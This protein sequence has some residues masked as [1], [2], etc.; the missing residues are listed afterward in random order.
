MRNSL[1]VFVLPCE[2]LGLWQEERNVI[3]QEIQERSF[4]LN[5]ER[6]EIDRENRFNAP[7][8]RDYSE[9]QRRV[10]EMQ[11]RVEQIIERENRITLNGRR[12][13]LQCIK[14]NVNYYEN[15]PPLRKLS[16]SQNVGSANSRL[17]TLER[18]SSFECSNTS[19]KTL[20]LS[21]QPQS[22]KTRFSRYMNELEPKKVQSSTSLH[23]RP[24]PSEKRMQTTSLQYPDSSGMPEV[25][26][27]A[28]IEYKHL[29]DAEMEGRVQWKN[30]V[31]FKKCLEL[32]TPELKDELRKL[33]PEISEEALDKTMFR[34]MQF[35]S[36]RRSLTEVERVTNI[37]DPGIMAGER[38]KYYRDLVNEYLEERGLSDEHGPIKDADLSSHKKIEE[39]DQATLDKFQ[40]ILKKKQEAAKKAKEA[41]VQES[42]RKEVLPQLPIKYSVHPTPYDRVGKIVAQVNASVAKASVHV[43]RKEHKSAFY[44]LSKRFDANLRR[45]HERKKVE[46]ENQTGPFIGNRTIVPV[47]KQ[48][49]Y[50]ASAMTL[51]ER[52]EYAE[53]LMQRFRLKTANAPMID[54]SA[55][56]RVSADMYCK[57]LIDN[58]YDYGVPPRY[59]EEPRIRRK[60]LE[61]S[62]PNY[63]VKEGELSTVLRFAWKGKLKKL[64]QVLK[65]EKFQKKI[66]RVD[67]LKRTALHYAASWGCTRTLN[68]LLRCPG[69]DVNMRDCH[70]K[71]PLYK[72]ME[73]G[74]IECV[75][76]LIKAGADTRIKAQDSRDALIHLL[77]FY[78]DE[79]FEM[80]KL[81]WDV[82]PRTYDNNK[83]GEM[84][85]L[86]KSLMSD[87]NIVLL[88]CIDYMLNQGCDVDAREGNGRTAA[89]IAAIDGRADI[90]QLLMAHHMNPLHKDLNNKTVIDY[91]LT[92][93]KIYDLLQN[94]FEYG[95]GD[96]A[97]ASNLRDGKDKHNMRQAEEYRTK[98]F[99]HR[100]L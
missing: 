54:E 13:Y 2:D 41:K 81:L 98:H 85:I 20:T 72:A 40:E 45:Q 32:C 82:S 51:N 96:I 37:M 3:G 93:T 43:P 68:I 21:R 4:L 100:F 95:P 15:C 48:H 26:S 84:N 10:K 63:T 9:K 16:N 39:E 42:E 50:E 94:Y 56:H 46:R 11:K 79:R 47:A 8:W 80:F 30:M 74:S 86:H 57:F 62:Y 83:L 99:G 35:D 91:T 18:Q 12:K 23:L 58:A 29:K 73:I 59:V 6:E 70:G 66:N 19:Q 31:V 60:I 65:D 24:T 77:H 22:S 27:E 76:A 44:N 64:R 7:V 55:G 17:M 61:G 69:A 89:H 92:G 52:R 67:G 38:V 14:P 88:K 34:F 36:V 53:E 97:E 71:T 49:R 78:G 25:Q 28:K 5:Q 33:D 1:K 90:L 75:K 87:K